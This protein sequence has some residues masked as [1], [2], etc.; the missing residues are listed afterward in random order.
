MKVAKYLL[1]SAVALVSAPSQSESLNVTQATMLQT[2]QQI[3]TV[4]AQDY[5][6]FEW[7]VESEKLDLKQEIARAKGV[8]ESSPDISTI[9]FQDLLVDIINALR[10]F[11]TSITFYSTEEATL[12]FQIMEAGGRFFISFV[13]RTKISK[14][15]FPFL[16]VGTEVV[17]FDGRPISEVVRG[18]IPERYLMPTPT[19]WRLAGFRLCYRARSAGMRVPQGEVKLTFKSRDGKLVSYPFFW[20]YTPEYVPLGIPVR[21]TMFSDSRPD[22]FAVNGKFGSEEPGSA[23]I[24]GKSTYVPELGQVFSHGSF[25][26]GNFSSQIYRLPSGAI[27][28]VIRIPTFGVPNPVESADEFGAHVTSLNERTDALVID[29]TR[30]NGG[31]LPYMYGLLSRLTDQPLIPLEQQIMISDSM[32]AESAQRLA[33]SMYVQSEQGA[34][35][36][37]GP[38]LQGMLANFEDFQGLIYNDRFLL[39]ELKAG[40]RLSQPTWVL[41]INKITPHPTQ[42]YTKPILVLVDELDF[43]AADFFPAIL[44]DNKRAVIFG[45]RTAGAGGSLKETQLPNQFNI[46]SLTYTWT[47]ARRKDGRPLEN[48]GVTPDIEYAIT[49]EDLQKNFEGYRAAVVRAVEGML[50][51]N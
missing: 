10:D 40:R 17:E 27:V 42:R 48:L 14:E 49:P 24:G 9:Q 6:P 2:L 32:A 16:E 8:I 21:N 37:V 50:R 43:S 3:M 38:I 30:N 39:S 15:S 33:A 29:L 47:I 18:L 19:E 22:K 46:R 45:T 13:D 34:R 44:Q 12:P 5:A 25:P 11:H 4:F 20:Q 51:K 1:F 23:E 36:I 7:K 26:P 31:S 41:G 35:E 28:G